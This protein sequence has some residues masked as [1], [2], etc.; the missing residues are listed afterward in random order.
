MNSQ[1]NWT[2]NPDPTK[3][4]DVCTRFSGP[5]PDRVVLVGSGFCNKVGSADTVFKLWSDLD[6]KPCALYWE[7]VVGIPPIKES[8]KKLFF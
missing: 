5:D 2:R 1:E 3:I 4:P 7:R 6:L 8:R